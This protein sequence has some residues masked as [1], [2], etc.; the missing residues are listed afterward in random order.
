[1]EEEEVKGEK[2]KGNDLKGKEDEGGIKTI[3]EITKPDEI[4]G[5]PLLNYVENAEMEKKYKVNPLPPAA[6][7]PPPPVAES[8]QLQKKSRL[9]SGAGAEVEVHR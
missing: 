2:N 4:E 8:S 7:N 1:M 3:C 9:C 5:K 6:V